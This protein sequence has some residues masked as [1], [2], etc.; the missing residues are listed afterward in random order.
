MSWL[1]RTLW[2]LRFW[3]AAG[4]LLLAA[5]LLSKHVEIDPSSKPENPPQIQPAPA[6][7]PA[8]DERLPVAGSPGYYVVVVDGAAYLE[9]P[10][11]D[12]SLLAKQLMPAPAPQLFPKLLMPQPAAAGGSGRLIVLDTGIVEVPKTGV[13]TLIEKDYLVLHHAD[14]TATA[15]YTDGRVVARKRLNSPKGKAP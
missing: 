4:G 7:K 2:R 10:D 8:A 1:L 3:L 5:F 11:G 9:N 15:H 14:G 6:V 13:I 12:R